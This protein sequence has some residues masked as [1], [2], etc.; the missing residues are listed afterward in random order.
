MWYSH[1]SEE[2]STFTNIMCCVIAQN[3]SL[4]TSTDCR[5]TKQPTYNIM[6]KEVVT[7][8][9]QQQIGIVLLIHI[10]FLTKSRYIKNLITNTVASI[11]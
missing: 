9:Y 5:Q 7:S 4:L 11:D 6:Y 3:H 10:L 1:V 8:Q 2:P